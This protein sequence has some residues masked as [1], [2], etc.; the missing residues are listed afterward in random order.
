MITGN[1]YDQLSSRARQ[2]IAASD[3]YQ[4]L[5]LAMISDDYEKRL[6]LMITKD[7]HK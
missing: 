1:Y 3:D 6:S 5:R 2:H 7:E 4:R